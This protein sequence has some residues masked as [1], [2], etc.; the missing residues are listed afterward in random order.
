MLSAALAELTHSQRQ[1]FVLREWRGL[2]YDEIAEE[3]DLSYAGV[4]TKVSR[5][6]K[7]VAAALERS[8]GTRVRDRLASFSPVS[9]LTGLRSILDSSEAVHALVV[10]AAV[11]GGGAL[12]AAPLLHGHAHHARPAVQAGSTYAPARAAYNA[13]DLA[14]PS[15]LLAAPRARHVRITLPAPRRGKSPLRHRSHSAG[16][17]AP[18]ASV[19]SAP[20]GRGVS[21][22]SAGG[23]DAGAAT[24]SGTSAAPD[25]A[26][27]AGAPFAPAHQT[28]PSSAETPAASTAPFP[29]GAHPAGGHSD[30]TGPPS[31][32]PAQAKQDAAASGN[33]KADHPG[34]PATPPGQAKKA[35]S[36]KANGRGAVPP[37][38]LKKSGSGKGSDKSGGPP[39]T[40]PGQ[41]K[42]NA[43][44]AT[45]DSSAGP[46]G[47][48]PGQVKK[49][50]SSS[51]A[52]GPQDTPPG[53]AKKDSSGDASTGN[54]GGPPATPPGQAKKDATASDPAA[55]SPEEPSSTDTASTSTT[56]SSSTPTDSSS[57]P[58]DPSA[59]VQA[60][61][62]GDPPAAPPGQAKKDSSDS[63]GSGGL[64][65]GQSKD[66]G[67]SG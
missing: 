34:P 31:T 40:P 66:H 27:S 36:D 33:G 5:A 11:A 44:T 35:S 52:A 21:P 67:K 23:S 22:S 18:G 60:Q 24:G 46:S 62:N 38:Q 4:A 1:V 16:L 55:A 30:P 3:L 48:P 8:W 7:T 12:V 59:T 2:S 53:Q 29:K 42:K 13:R 50:A 65:P 9:L 26:P 6:R 25:A 61:S 37:G 19:Q 32:P 17:A 64:P 39:A 58:T 49:N 47:A 20:A 54:G 63:N 28:A 14:V 41:A 45:G 57:T 10:A 15:T 56:D 51:N 43:D